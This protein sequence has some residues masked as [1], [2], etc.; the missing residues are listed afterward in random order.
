LRKLREMQRSADACRHEADARTAV[1]PCSQTVRFRGDT[2]GLSLSTLETTAIAADWRV[3]Y[4]SEY[5]RGFRTGTFRVKSRMCEE[6][7]AVPLGMAGG[8]T[9]V[10]AM[11]SCPYTPAP[12]EAPRIF[13]GG[14]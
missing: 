7:G 4:R 6:S 2:F 11:G 13:P 3:V 14:A 8:E 9:P 10:R 5:G 12:G 1:A